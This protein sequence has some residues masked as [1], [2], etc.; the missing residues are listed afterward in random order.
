MKLSDEF[1][2]ALDMLHANPEVEELREI[3][4]DFINNGSDGVEYELLWG[5]GEGCYD[6][7]F[8][9]GENIKIAK[10]VAVFDVINY[11]VTEYGHRF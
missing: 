10:A 9:P 4:A 7:L 11:Y 5:R 8:A 6:H 3:V 2:E 1:R